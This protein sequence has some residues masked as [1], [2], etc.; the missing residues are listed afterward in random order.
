[1]DAAAILKAVCAFYKLTPKALLERTQVPQIVWPRHELTYLMRQNTNLGWVL[2]GRAMGG[3]D[4]ST[5]KNAI[6]QVT[7]RIIADDDY[8]EHIGNLQRFV[9]LFVAQIEAP[10]ELPL[11]LAR[12]VIAAP[13]PSSSDIE[14]IGLCLLTAASI[15]GNG[16]LTDAEARRAALAVLGSLSDAA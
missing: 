16:D 10:A 9:Q 2:I 11:A 7:A 15:L 14:R 4:Q 5:V 12:R 6:D 13:E 3:R 8:A 1:M